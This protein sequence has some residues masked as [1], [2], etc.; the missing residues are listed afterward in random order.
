MRLILAR[1]GQTTS[2]LI[3]ALDTAAP[4]ASLTEDG[5]KQARRLGER[6]D[7][8]IDRVIAS[9]LVR[10]QQTAALACSLE[11]T[12][13]PRIAEVSA[14]VWEM[15]HDKE[16]H[17]A[18]FGTCAEWMGGHLAPAIDGG[19]SGHE[20]LARFNAALVDAAEA[21]SGGT[22]LLVCHGMMLQV[23]ASHTFGHQPHMINC[24]FAIA[25]GEPGN[26][27]LTHW[28]T[29]KVTTPLSQLVR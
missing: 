23:W 18:Y 9:H 24:A 5:K 19:E 16:A 10:T 4:G 27:T 7:L 25:D 28:P 8:P 21:R 12:I 20:V 13:D 2:N 1:H 3:R 6:L 15:R 29:G 22:T 26:W 14:G 11:A 17:R